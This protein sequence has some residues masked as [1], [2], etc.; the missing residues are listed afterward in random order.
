M[1]LCGAVGNVVDNFVGR[2]T[3]ASTHP[4]MTVGQIVAVALYVVLVLLVG[5]Y[6]WNEVLCKVTTVCKPM[7][8]LLH[9]VGLVVLL[10]LLRPSTCNC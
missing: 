2:D 3:F 9:L 1:S 4:H 8:S 5:K 10:D 7:P 6:L